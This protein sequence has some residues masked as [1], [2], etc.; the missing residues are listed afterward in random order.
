LQGREK[1]A[2]NLVYKFLILSETLAY[3]SNPR[4]SEYVDGDV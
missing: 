3:C 1:W 2:R 4:I